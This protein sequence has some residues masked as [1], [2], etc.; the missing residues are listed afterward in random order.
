MFY[1]VAY[2]I[3][4]R[5]FR[6]W[7]VNAFEIGNFYIAPSRNFLSGNKQTNKQTNKQKIN[8]KKGVQKKSR[9]FQTCESVEIMCTED[10]QDRVRMQ[11]VKNVMQ[12]IHELFVS[13]CEITLA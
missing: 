2:Y 4:D 8:T 10:V 12:Q 1:R 3:Q 13:L 5:I 11:I 7:L 6:F 9:L